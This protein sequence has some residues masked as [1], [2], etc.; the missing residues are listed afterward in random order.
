MSVSLTRKKIAVGAVVGSMLIALLFL[1]RCVAEPG[2]W[3]LDPYIG[4]VGD[5]YVILDS[6]SIYLKTPE[7]NELLGHYEK[8]GNTWTSGNVKGHIP[9]TFEPALLGIRVISPADGTDHFYYRRCFKWIPEV[10]GWLREKVG[11]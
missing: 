11:S 1:W 10:N 8:V 6:G 7:S 5:A 3:Y 4:C 2:G 9:D